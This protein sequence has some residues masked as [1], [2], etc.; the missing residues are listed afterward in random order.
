METFWNSTVNQCS[1]TLWNTINHCETLSTTV[2]HSETHWNAKRP[3]QFCFEHLCLTYHTGESCGIKILGLKCLVF[4]KVKV[5][6]GHAAYLFIL[7][8]IA[9][10]MSHC[11]RFTEG[12]AD[13]T[14]DDHL[15]CWCTRLTS[16]NKYSTDWNTS[17]SR[18]PS[19]HLLHLISTIVALGTTYRIYRNM[20]SLCSRS[21]RAIE[22]YQHP[23]S[24]RASK[25]SISKTLHRLQDRY[26]I[27]PE[28]SHHLQATIALFRNIAT[29]HYHN[30]ALPSC[31]RAIQQNPVRLCS[32][33]LL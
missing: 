6:R 21:I 7:W 23:R 20:L 27:I 1:E 32:M 25:M 16:E 9:F 31:Y 2:N 22:Q 24:L 12:M 19:D 13:T 10:L 28:M 5:T 30:V 3:P 4:R 26:S 33:A 14:V 18:L 29:S 15:C 17:T 11:K 8:P